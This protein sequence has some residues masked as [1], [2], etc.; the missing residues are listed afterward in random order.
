MRGCGAA[1][2]RRKPRRVPGKGFGARSGRWADLSA[3]CLPEALALRFG[4]TLLRGALALVVFAALR[5]GEG[6]AF[7]RPVLDFARAI[8]SRLRTIVE[9]RRET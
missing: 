7:V 9:K 3:G 4:F 2:R 8:Q 6:F 1:G 5:R